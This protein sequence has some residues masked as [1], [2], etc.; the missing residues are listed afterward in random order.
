MATAPLESDEPSAVGTA[1]AG[2]Y[3]YVPLLKTKAGEI[4]ALDNLDPGAKSRIL[5]LFHACADVKPSFAPQLI[6]A[7]I[8]GLV[9]IDGVFNF[10][11]TGNGTAFVSLVQ[12]LRNGGVF[13]MPCWSPNDPLPYQHAARMMVDGNGAVIKVSL[14]NLPTLSAWVAQQ[15]LH[16]IHTD[17]VI[18]MKHV[19][20]SDMGT[21]SGYVSTMLN[22][23]APTLI[24]FRSVTLAGAAAPKDNTSLSLGVNRV[25]RTDWILWTSVRVTVPFRLDYGDYLTGHPDLTEPPGVAIAS[26]TVSA[27]YTQ[28]NSW[29]IIK[30]RSASGQNGLPMRQQYQSHAGVIVADAGFSGVPNVWADSQIGLAALGAPGMASRAKWSGYA[31]NRHLSLV[32]DRLP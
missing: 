11:Q 31:A 10:G 4:A 20:A 19:G 2:I 7:W 27:R 26:A 14:A 16:A 30:G 29:L 5:P 3:R 24:G 17:I 9:A 21:F 1:A 32:A 23:A 25:P 6:S 13:T 12:A 18:D 22:S 28:D 8:G 15:G